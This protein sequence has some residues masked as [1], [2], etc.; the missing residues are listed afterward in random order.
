MAAGPL[1]AR[2]GSKSAAALSGPQTSTQSISIGPPCLIRNTTMHPPGTGSAPSVAA[3]MLRS[4]EISGRS[5][6]R[7]SRRNPTLCRSQRP[8]SRGANPPA[9][10]S[11]K[12]APRHFRFCQQMVCCRRRRDAMVQFVERAGLITQRLADDR[13]RDR[14]RVLDATAEF[15]ERAAAAGPVLYVRTLRARNCRQNACKRP[16]M[17][18]ET[19]IVQNDCGKIVPSGCPRM[20][21][22]LTMH[23]SGSRER[24]SPMLHIRATVGC[25]R[26]DSKASGRHRNRHD[27]PKRRSRH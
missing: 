17:P 11:L 3:L 6:V 18:R 26:C 1:R 2:A 24:C 4:R 23:G 19:R 10:I 20:A 8:G 16:S 7:T 14:Q 22:D 13:W 25:R 12:G 9:R 15:H 27:E 5:P 21:F